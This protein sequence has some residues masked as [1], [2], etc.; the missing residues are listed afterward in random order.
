[1]VSN[2]PPQPPQ[3]QPHQKHIPSIL[4]FMRHNDEM[5]TGQVQLLIEEMQHLRDIT[6]REELSV[7]SNNAWVVAQPKVNSVGHQPNVADIHRP[8]PMASFPGAS[9]SMQPNINDIRA[10]HSV[11]PNDVWIQCSPQAESAAVS[12]AC[13]LSNATGPPQTES[14]QESS[15]FLPQ[16][17]A[18]TIDG[19][20][21]DE[22]VEQNY[23][24]VIAERN[25]FE[26]MAT[27]YKNQLHSSRC[28]LKLAFSGM[29]HAI[30][31]SP[32]GAQKGIATSDR[33]GMH[34]FISSLN[35]FLRINNTWEKAETALNSNKNRK[36]KH[37]L[38]LE[39]IE[40]FKSFTLSYP[41]MADT[42]TVEPTFNQQ[43]EAS[44]QPSSTRG[45]IKQ[46][47]AP[48]SNAAP[49]IQ[50]NAFASTDEFA[51]Q[52]KDKPTSSSE[53]VAAPAADHDEDVSVSTKIVLPCFQDM[54]I[55]SIRL[56]IGLG[57][58]KDIIQLTEAS[59]AEKLLRELVAGNIISNPFHHGLQ[60]EFDGWYFRKRI[61][62]KKPDRL[63][64]A[65]YKLLYILW[66]ERKFDKDSSKPEQF[67]GDEHE[68]DLSRYGKKYPEG[69]WDAN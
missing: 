30:D 69:Y 3:M 60:C 31:A 41:G 11:T 27:L 40:Q 67:F 16:Q 34:P 4:D 37:E 7:N 28:L 8:P 58:Q 57:T 25:N 32:L 21:P 52:I 38:C 14:I 29:F 43:A 22:S 2:R 54:G 68:P 36:E 35:T 45:T 44:E 26:R 10:S 62:G 50:A 6:R 63:M 20:S 9:S 64:I 5:L 55:Q 59:F 18:E 19:S 66:K 53:L 61:R 51:G 17:Q 56:R 24:K 65:K 47:S 49:T 42:Q 46:T 12:S 48:T 39:I 13:V 15:A 1:M 23:E 33:P